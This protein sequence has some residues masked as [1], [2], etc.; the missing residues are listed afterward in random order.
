MRERVERARARLDS[1]LAFLLRLR[2]AC[3]ARCSKRRKRGPN[4]GRARLEAFEVSNWL[5]CTQCRKD[6]F[7]FCASTASQS[8]ISSTSCDRMGDTSKAVRK[9]FATRSDIMQVLKRLPAPALMSPSG[10]TTQSD[11]ILREIFTSVAVGIAANGQEGQGQAGAV[12]L[13]IGYHYGERPYN[14]SGRVQT[15][16]ELKVALPQAQAGSS[17]AGGSPLEVKVQLLRRSWRVVRSGVSHAAFRCA[18]LRFAAEA[19][20]TVGL[21]ALRRRGTCGL[22]RPRRRRSAK[23]QKGEISQPPLCTHSARPSRCASTTRP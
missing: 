7:S 11:S 8:K 4:C 16:L 5:C 2:L 12:G 15:T 14:L 23:K 21:R 19:L 9:L 18:S 20:S 22:E 3:V 1:S 6:T 17:S 10:S 13:A